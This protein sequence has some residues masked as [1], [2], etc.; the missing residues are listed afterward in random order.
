[1]RAARVVTTRSTFWAWAV[2]SAA[3]FEASSAMA[4]ALARSGRIS[5]CTEVM[6]CCA[7]ASAACAFSTAC[8]ACFAATRR[9]HDQADLDRA[10]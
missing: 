10:P 6:V 9:H 8:C 3:V 5:S 4:L 1:M 2:A 7:V